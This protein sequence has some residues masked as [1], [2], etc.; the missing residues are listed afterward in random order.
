[1]QLCVY[2]MRL[3]TETM[4]NIVSEIFVCADR[5]VL[6]VLLFVCTPNGIFLHNIGGGFW[7]YRITTKDEKNSR[8]NSNVSGVLTFYLTFASFL[9]PS[10]S[11]TISEFSNCVSSNALIIYIT[12]SVL[13]FYSFNVKLVILYYIYLSIDSYQ[14]QSLIFPI[15]FL[16]FMPKFMFLIHDKRYKAQLIVSIIMM[17]V[18]QQIFLLKNK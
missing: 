4:K 3:Y 10:I 7:H 9:I 11:K 8:S 13:V 5:Q 17:I 14:F 1:M 15:D 2:I 16:H 6:Q 18:I 12:F